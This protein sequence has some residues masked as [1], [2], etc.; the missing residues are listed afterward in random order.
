MNYARGEIVW[1]KFPFSDATTAKLRP[2]PIISND[3][4]NRT[5]DYLLIQVTS[6]LRNDNLSFSI[7]EADFTGSPY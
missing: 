2:A 1:V 4:V 3:L 7:K 5:R 6:H